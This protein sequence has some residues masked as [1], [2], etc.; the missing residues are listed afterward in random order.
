MTLI[1]GI[2]EKNESTYELSTLYALKVSLNHLWCGDF[3]QVIS[4]LKKTE[5]TSDYMAF[6]VKSKISFRKMRI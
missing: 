4:A 5:V 1:G 6:I 3:L 2:F